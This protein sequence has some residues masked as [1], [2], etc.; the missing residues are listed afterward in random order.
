MNKNL[1]RIMALAPQGPHGIAVVAAACRASAFGII[2]LTSHTPN[3][4]AEVF[5]QIGRLT[6][7]RYCVR[8][9]AEDVFELAGLA[10]DFAGLDAVCV[11]V[12]SDDVR[13]LESAVRAIRRAGRRALVEVTSRVE[14]RLAR[15]AGADM[16]IVAGTEAGGRGG[17]ESSFV[18]LQAA[19]AEGE[20]SVWVRGG[21]GPNVA[22][23][24]VAAGAAGIVL[25]GALLLA[26]ESPLG[27]QWRE[28]I[29]RW[30]GSETTVVGPGSGSSVRVFAPPGSDA[31]QRLRN[32]AQ[33]GGSS[34]QAAVR[35]NVGW[36]E[37]Q[38]LPVGQDAALADKLARKYVTVGGIVQAVERAITDGIAAGRAARPLAETSPLAVAHGTRFPVLQGPMTRVSDVPGFAQAVARG[39]GLPFLALALLRAPEVR[40]LLRESA[41]ALA[42]RPWGVG[43]LG[44]VPPELRAQ[45]LAAVR[46]IRPPFALIAGGRPD[47]G[48]ELERAGI[49]TYLHVPS[50]GLLEQYLRDGS[51]RFVLEGRECGGHVGPRSSFV[52]WEQAVG[53]VAEAIDRGIAADQVS[54]VFA[55]GIHDARS[56]AL[57]ATVAG[58]LAAR[59]VKVGVLLG[60]AYLF[61]REAVSTGAIVPGFQNEVVRCDETVLLESGP[62]HQVRVSRTPYVTRFEQERSSLTAQGRSVEEIREALEGLNVGRLR[63]AAKGIDRS[64]GAG[65]PLVAVSDEY[66]ASHGLYMLGQV[67]TLR[68]QTT[69]IADLHH[70]VCTHSAELLD[71]VAVNDE[72]KGPHASRPQPSDVAIIGMSA[73]F[74][75]AASVTR[76][77]SNTL[78][79]ID[80]ITEVPP[81]RWDW[82]LY[83]D[84]DPKAPDKIVSKWGGFVP[85]VAFDPLRYGMPPSSLPSIEP[86]QLLALEV[87]RTALADAGYADR[88]FHREQTAVVLGM[89]GG[90]AQLAMGYAFRSYLPML[91]TVLPAAGRQAIESCEGLLPEWTEDSFPGFLLNVTAG[92]IANRLNL[93]GANYTVDAA[94][95]SSLAAAS[96]AV[97]ELETGAADM[98]ILGGVDTVQNPFTYLAF[99][100]TQAFSPRGRCRPFDSS[101]D[102]IVISEGVAAVVL[103][104]LADA[105]RDG[106][107]IY[108][109]IKGVGASSDGRG[110]GLT[111]PVVEGQTRALE[112][113]Y[114]KAGVSPATIGYV[115][116]HGTGTALGDVVEVEA[117]GELFKEAGA[118]KRACALGSVK[119]LIGHTKCAAGLAGLINA[120]LALHHKV[121]PPT[122]GI[123]TPNAKLDLRD[124]P[125]RLCKETQPWLHHHA[126]RPRRAGV[127]AFGFGGTNF[128]AVLE[129][130]DR[131]LVDDLEPTMT[132]W[133]CEL[134]VWQTDEPR[135][136]LDELDHLAAAL[137]AG[138]RPALEDLAH[139]LIQAKRARKARGQEA[140][141]ATLA[142]VAASL[143]DLRD[144]LKLARAAIAEGR[145]SLDDRRGVVFEAR[146]T[147]A[148]AKVA[149]VF[150]GQGAQSPGMLR[151]LAVT[152]PVVRDAF[153]EFDRM[154][155]AGGG[156]PVG[157]LIFAP[158]VFGAVAEA[159]DQRALMPTEVAQPAVGAA[160]LAV[161]RLLEQLGC[162]PDLCG[163]HSYGELV[164]LHAAGALSASALAQLSQARGRFMRDAARGND[165]AMA[166]LV[167]GPDDVEQLLR[168]VP[169]VQPANWNGPKQT[170]IAGPTVAVKHAIEL[171]AT[172]GIQGRLLAVS[173]AFHTPMVAAAGAPL[174]ELAGRLLDRAP[175]IPIYSNLDARPHPADPRAVAARLGQHLAG[176]VRFAEMIK[177][178]YTDGARVFV[179][180]GPGSILSSLIGTI[181]GDRAHLAVACDPPGSA[182]LSGWLCALARLVTAGVPLRLEQLTAGRSERVLD[183]RHLPAGDGADLTPSTWMVNGSRARPANAPEPKRLGQAL[184]RPAEYGES[185]EPSRINGFSTTKNA[186]N[187]LPP[188]SRPAPQPMNGRNGE[189]TNRNGAVPPRSVSKPNGKL[190]PY[191][192]MK[193]SSHPSGSS[194]R[195]I[196]S[197]Q[198][199]MQAFLEV[200]KSTMLAYLA[201]RGAAAPKGDPARYDVP[202]LGEALVPPHAESAPP[203]QISNGNG[204]V[205]DRF[206]RPH[207]HK[208]SDSN[209]HHHESNG[210]HGMQNGKG[211]EAHAEKS[212]A[213]AP[214]RAEIAARLLETV[215]DRTGYPIETLGLDLD[216]EADLGIDSIK[217]VE[218]LGKLRDEFPGLKALSDTPEMMDAMA[219][220][221]TLGVIVERMSS[222]TQPPSSPVSVP[223][224]LH[225]RALDQ[226]A[227]NGSANGNGK[228]AS[229]TQRR[230][231]EVVDAPLPSEASGLMAGGRIV[232][233]DDTRGVAHILERHLQENGTPVERLGG[234]DEPVDWTS[235]SSIDQAL[236]RL[237]SRGP[238]A[239]IVHALPLGNATSVETIE[240]DWSAQVGVEVRG[241]F[242]AAKAMAADLENAA[243][244]GGACLIAA[245]ALGGRFASAG[246]QASEFFPGQGGVAGLVKTLAREWPSIRAR[247]VDFSSSL[248]METIA[249]QLAAEVFAGDGWA[250]VGYDQGRRIRLRTVARAAR[251][252]RFHAGAQP[253]RS[254][255]NHRGSTG[256]H[257]SGG[258]RVGA[259]LEADPVDR[260]HHAVAR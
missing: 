112:R 172:R 191:T 119:S 127:S 256:D 40:A 197:F 21:V 233:T 58:P 209:G 116:A 222:L 240:A 170:V 130:Y 28:R 48:A 184:T 26:R 171:A 22:A 104:R 31:L 67:A 154:L 84:A 129:A 141:C 205:V 110:R 210:M 56:A 3:E 25:D 55:G 32:A 51:R 169:G 227:T 50:P 196:E 181:L 258:G 241:L 163:G 11:P 247:V 167:A 190:E 151:D 108:A 259:A 118:D 33:D 218:I 187:G 166:A 73:V 8:L 49:A 17:T 132:D 76:F 54:L 226:A 79:G 75:G 178:M 199:T 253:G 126:D 244:A 88:P 204:S 148:G 207:D 121:L 155:L 239:G 236:E 74:P 230:I 36:K 86:A 182:G 161:L 159:E 238:L 20:A 18:L 93:G 235:P 246:S 95:G 96:L 158:P 133:P 37:G 215:R 221:R 15:A 52:L 176:P 63:I 90:A 143:T 145:P 4:A 82:R 216:M 139:T 89:G 27:V 23:G 2:D 120:S 91:D 124:G 35:Q 69:T 71:H 213:G 70:E 57:V 103:K 94:C 122:I 60:T 131:K 9:S 135:Q 24:C 136:L 177:T 66:Q 164:A 44:F 78:M 7:G 80:A 153:E 113:A 65:S 81:D 212:P 101:A 12:D 16:L 200:Q 105:E 224:K 186:T 225:T 254:R 203:S 219:R 47:Q 228:P 202:S 232:I 217:R 147:W 138:A 242:L 174:S 234:P 106:D 194:D 5:R 46:E 30:D 92:R 183:I 160:C 157:P 211:P 229:A 198:Q 152:F 42:G 137:D 125:F 255:V 237:R 10:S 59:G 144:K 102:G 260:G 168:D 250:E 220:A 185:R 39:G 249:T 180:V 245:T 243:R 6:S 83:Y 179:E 257:G 193:N 13:Q 162:Q 87:V 117:L 77:W 146:P 192:P 34:W 206:A 45:Q 68:S 251:P 175:V 223:G 62:G 19:L 41:V 173:S 53:V 188:F 115:E 38:C 14:L 149:F 156:P 123:E 189:T 165:G 61:T 208:K 252:R 150:P 231:L 111:A 214:D 107:R 142:I 100:K 248:P 1:P 43:I 29:A 140:D 128:H 64:E 195:V 201:G 72:S 99:S 134:L 98:V 109:V 114:H 97:R 85:D